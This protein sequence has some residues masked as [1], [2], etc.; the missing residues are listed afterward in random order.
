MSFGPLV[1]LHVSGATIGLL[2]G[3]FAMLVRKGGSL[4]RLT[5]TIFFGA[6]TTMSLSGAILAIFVRPNRINGIVA[7]LA[8]Y[9]V[10]TSW[11]AARIREVKIRPLDI[12]AFIFILL[13]G[14]VAMNLGFVAARN[15]GTLDHMP[16][17]MYFMF[18]SIVLMFAYGDLRMLRRG[19]VSGQK[20]IA[21]HLWR[22]CVV[23]LLAA[24]SFYPGQL[25]L[26]PQI[27]HRFVLYL[28]HIFVVISMIYWRRRVLKPRNAPQPFS[29]RPA[30][31]AYAA[32]VSSAK[33]AMA[34]H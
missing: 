14:I 29:E 18:G 1:L 25:K 20:R 31:N 30:N 7:L 24:L 11:W 2:S 28:P 3:M 23:L 15:G 8:F 26:F 21:R 34:S 17:M 9:L 4:H 12:A 19:G 13:N 5:G 16:A 33:N 10:L 32:T 22:M 27:G 6:M